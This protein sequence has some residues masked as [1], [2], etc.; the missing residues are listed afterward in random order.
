M[1]SS[2]ALPKLML[3]RPPATGPARLASTSVALRIQS[4]STAMP[5]APVINIHTGGNPAR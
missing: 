5:M 3:M 1:I 4:E 2:G